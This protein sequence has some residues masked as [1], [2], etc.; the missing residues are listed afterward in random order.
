MGARVLLPATDKS[1]SVDET[2]VTFLLSRVAIVI[3]W[4]S[5]TRSRATM[6]A[7]WEQLDTIVNGFALKKEES[8]RAS[9]SFASSSAASDVGHV[10][11]SS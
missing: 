5:F 11:G 1:N 7:K 6:S 3:C 4:F 8:S 9:S 10:C 2:H